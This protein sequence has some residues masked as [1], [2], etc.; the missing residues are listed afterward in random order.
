MFLSHK[1]VVSY[2]RCRRF[3]IFLMDS[4]CTFL[5]TPATQSQ[6]A[7]LTNLDSDNWKLALFQLFV[8]FIFTLFCQVRIKNIITQYVGD[9]DGCGVEELIKELMQNSDDAQATEVWSFSSLIDIIYDYFFIIVGVCALMTS[10]LWYHFM[11]I[12]QPACLCI[13]HVVLWTTYVLAN[14]S[15]SLT[16][17]NILARYA[18]TFS[19]TIYSS[20][21]SIT[22][23]N[24]NVSTL[25]LYS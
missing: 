1:T 11:F 25:T 7:V 17:G 16:R 9:R 14:G 12:T 20:E 2:Q 5:Y 15:H 21:F 6:C 23:M 22:L 10:Y 19:T 3:E 13:Y 18:Q 8:I 24:D 4:C